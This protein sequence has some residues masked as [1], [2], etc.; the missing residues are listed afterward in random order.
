MFLSGTKVSNTTCMKKIKIP[1]E[2]TGFGHF[3]VFA[4]VVLG[5]RTCIVVAEMEKL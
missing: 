2:C 1:Y 3:G 5:S 4:V